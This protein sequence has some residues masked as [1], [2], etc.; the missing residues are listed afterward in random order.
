MRFGLRGRLLTGLLVTMIVAIL[1]VTSASIKLIQQL[2]L[3]EEQSENLER[4][5]LYQKA[6]LSYILLDALFVSILG[7]IFITYLVIRPISRLVTATECVAKGDL[8]VKLAFSSN[9]ELGD[10]AQG[11]D[12]M[13]YQ[14]NRTQ[15][16]LATQ[17]ETLTATQEELI[18]S[19]KLAMIGQIAAGIAHEIGNPLAAVIGMNELI[20]MTKTDSNTQDLS[21]R[22]AHELDRM[23][24]IIRELLDYAR[25]N[26]TTQNNEN[27]FLDQIILQAIGF[28]AHHPNT[29][30]LIITHSI[31]ENLPSLQGDPSRLTQVLMNLILNA[32]DALKG[33]GKVEIQ[34]ITEQNI[35]LL[36]VSDNGP[37]IDPKIKKSLFTPFITTKP[38]GA[39]TGLGLAL[40]EQIIESFGG[41]IS[42]E[43]TSNKGT[44]F[45]M[46]F[47][48]H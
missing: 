2:S 21:V 37:G 31:E 40:C 47:F 48:E 1:L 8:N 44:T 34:A 25:G 27:V 23:H 45:L 6:M 14:L 28:C 12:S 16:A 24:K 42:L 13:V 29:K 30:N 5:N 26:E 19:E 10:L 43:K 38:I 36:R 32:G 15:K 35:V 9:D 41:E 18:R 11:F 20:L 46:R 7:Y 3:S 17:I 33:K 22:I 39:G 4:K